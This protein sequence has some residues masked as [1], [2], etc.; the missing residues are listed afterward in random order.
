M[1][2]IKILIKQNKKNEERLLA[3]QQEQ[4]KK[5][6]EIDIKHTEYENQL[7]EKYG[8]IT[9]IISNTMYDDE[10]L[11]RYDDI[12]VFKESKKVIIKKEEYDFTDILT[13]TIY[14]E[15]LN[16]NRITQVTKTKTSNM[17][18]RAAIGGLILGVPGAVAGAAT[19]KTES[20]YY[21]DNFNNLPSYVVKIG[22]KS[23]ENPSIILRYDH[24][25]EK[26]E[27]VYELIQAIIAIK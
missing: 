24:D 12:Y 19:A 21:N 3:I 23:I 5:Q 26:A 6:K 14:D 8:N 22:I 13:C 18:E 4:E 15:N 1:Y 20:A 10:L 17:L 2:G 9:R 7:I 27:E 16:S 11:K 25:K